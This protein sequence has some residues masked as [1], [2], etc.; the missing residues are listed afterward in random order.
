MKRGLLGTAPH[1]SWWPWVSAASSGVSSA[2]TCWAPSAH[3]VVTSCNM[4]SLANPLR[5]F[6]KSSCDI[7]GEQRHWNCGDCRWQYRETPCVTWEGWSP[8]TN[9]VDGT[10]HILN[11]SEFQWL[12]QS[13]P[14]EHQGRQSHV[15]NSGWKLGHS[16]KL[17]LGPMTGYYICLTCSLCLRH[18]WMF[19]NMSG[20][21]QASMPWPS[22]RTLVAI[23]EGGLRD[24]SLG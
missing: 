8:R 23:L 11:K 21:P 14:G 15:D 1:V 6:G 13:V 7:E 18:N 20:F 5:S 12:S 2:L 9:N 24:M 16:R 4:A 22:Y 19:F 3:L 10:E 17:C